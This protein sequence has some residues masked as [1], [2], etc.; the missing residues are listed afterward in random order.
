MALFKR[1][2]L[3]GGVALWGATVLVAPW[4]SQPAPR[5]GV[6][7]TLSLIA[8]G[9][10]LVTLLAALVD[11]KWPGREPDPLLVSAWSLAQGLALAFLVLFGVGVLSSGLGVVPELVVGALVLGAGAGLAHGWW[12]TRRPAAAARAGDATGPGS[13]PHAPG[14]IDLRPLWFI[15]G[16]A[17]A[18]L[19]VFPLA[20]VAN[21]FRGPTDGF[22]ELGTVLRVYDQTPIDRAL[23]AAMAGLGWCLGVFLAWRRASL[24]F[25]AGLVAAATLLGL[26]F[27]NA[28]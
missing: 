13:V 25:V 26:A 6:D 11:R 14:G 3:F 10:I 5:A 18:F 9:V 23:G 4:S 2:L 15:L 16:C 27:A 17:A 28:G 19:L 12:I 1:A 7:A 24:A 21:R 20:L 8:T 22:T